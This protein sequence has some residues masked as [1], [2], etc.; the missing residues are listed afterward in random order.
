MTAA[1]LADLL[2]AWR[3]LTGVDLQ[4]AETPSAQ[5]SPGL[6][7]ALT[8]DGETLGELSLGEL[9]PDLSPTQARGWLELC[10]QLLSAALGEKRVADGLADE[11]TLAWNQLTFLYEVLKINSPLSDPWENAEKLSRLASQVFLCRNAMIAFKNKNGLTYRSA[12]PLSDAEVQ[13]YFDEVA[14]AGVVALREA[15]DGRPSFLGVKVPLATDGQAI[16]GLIGSEQGAFNAGDRQLAESLAEQIGTIMDNLTLQRQLTATLRLR[17]ELEIAAEIQASLLPVRLPQPAGVELA[18]IVA[19]ASRVGG[20]FYD[21]VELDDNSLGVIVGDVAGK[22]IPAAMFTTL[23]RTELRGQLLARSTPGLALRRTNA[24]LQPDLERLET[25]A[26]ALALRLDPSTREVIYASAGHTTSL[27]WQVMS[28]SPTQ[29]QSTALPLGILPDLKTSERIFTARPGD[30]IV[31][32]SDGVTEAENAA[33]KVFGLEG[34]TD[35]LFAAHPASATAIL[36][37]I[38]DGVAAHRGAQA[39]SD[40]LTVLVIKLHQPNPAQ[41]YRPFVLPAELG[42]LKKLDELLRDVF[43]PPA[44]TPEL[45]TWRQE[46]LLAVTELSSNIIQH[47]YADQPGARLHGLFALHADRVTMDT[48]D[49]GEAFD[50]PPAPPGQPDPAH[51]TGGALAEPPDAAALAEGGY[52]LRILHSAMDVVRYRRLFPNRNHWRLEKRL[53]PL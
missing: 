16:I 5:P 32:Y 39:V 13:V 53:P 31:L 18:G 12:A 19:P 11:V 33:G 46:F 29:L 26:T 21:V 35:V 37:A 22:G 15:Q 34:L 9:P 48:I 51:A 45:E 1:P 47:A 17:H 4:Y 25:F 2:R 30:V 14:Q 44:M 41:A 38:L 49:S 7:V 40:D 27:R 28:Q 20:D 8:Y 10:G 43:D 6:S 52:G 50:M 42:Q 23:V 3:A 24:A 36:Q